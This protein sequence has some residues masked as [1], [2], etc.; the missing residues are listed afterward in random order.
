MTP[1]AFRVVIKRLEVD[2]LRVDRE[3]EAFHDGA[4]ALALQGTSGPVRSKY[5][6]AVEHGRAPRHRGA[7]PVLMTLNVVKAGRR[8]V[9]VG[10]AEE[11]EDGRGRL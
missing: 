9:R 2:V 7:R 6:L 5:F 4:A 1:F 11:L 8:A 10:R 3:L